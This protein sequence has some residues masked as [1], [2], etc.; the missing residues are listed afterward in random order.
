MFHSEV[1][2]RATATLA[3]GSL[4]FLGDWGG[5]P[6]LVVRAREVTAEPETLEQLLADLDAVFVAPREP[7]APATMLRWVVTNP[8]H[9]WRW[10]DG[11]IDNGIWLHEKFAC[12]G[13][14]I[15]N[16]ME[17]LSGKE[18]RLQYRGPM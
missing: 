5:Q 8:W 18:P 14:L 9:E 17:V 7:Y 15:V 2:D 11:Q 4:M 6:Y 10:K 3:L 13:V 12:R 16:V 1:V